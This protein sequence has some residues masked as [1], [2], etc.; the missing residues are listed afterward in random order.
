MAVPG[1][2]QEACVAGREQVGRDACRAEPGDR[3][4]RGRGQGPIQAG[5]QAGAGR[6]EQPAEH[7]QWRRGGLPEPGDASGRV[8]DRW[9]PGL[10]DDRGGMRSQVGTRHQ[11][12]SAL[13]DLDDAPLPSARD[14]PRFVQRIFGCSSQRTRSSP[15]RASMRE[16][17]SMSRSSRARMRLQNGETRLVQESWSRAASW[18]RARTGSASKPASSRPYAWSSTVSRH[19]PS[20]RATSAG[21][22]AGSG[23]AGPQSP[24]WRS[25]AA[26][27][28][29]ARLTDC[30]SV[31]S[32]TPRGAPILRGG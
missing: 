19:N 5:Q 24:A 15:C 17:S 25:G 26:A 14:R 16:R 13:A 27:R 2:G 30:D 8:D 22:V 18:S 12:E 21:S 20:L 29:P 28:Q 32:A 10:L 4:E 31:P 3:G 9:Q 6:A 11:Q 7:V 1:G 23:P